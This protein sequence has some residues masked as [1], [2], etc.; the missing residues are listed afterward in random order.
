MLH[1]GHI[2]ILSQKGRDEIVDDGLDP[3]CARDSPVCR[4]IELCVRLI[5]RCQCCDTSDQ[6]AV[7][8]A[9]IF[10]AATRQSK[11]DLG[12]YKA[13]DQFENDRMFAGLM[14]KH[15]PTGAVRDVSL[16]FFF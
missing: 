10:A 14:L 6:C 5:D 2:F 1:H 9:D 4:V 12:L 7:A 15:S 11:A 8:P 16:G 3:S 13:T